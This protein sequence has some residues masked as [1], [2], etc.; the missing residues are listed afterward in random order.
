MSNSAA[1]PLQFIG[2]FD[3]LSRCRLWIALD[4]GPQVSA[5]V[6]PG[7]FSTD[8]RLSEIDLQR[9]KRF[10]SPEKQRQF[11]LSRIAVAEVL[12]Q[13]LG[14]EHDNVRFA[15]DSF[16]RPVV[17]DHNHREV[18]QI[19]LSHSGPVTAIAVSNDVY[20][21][22]VDVELV[23]PI[24]ETALR[25]MIVLP[26]DGKF[27]ASLH[28]VDQSE[29]LRMLWTIKESVWKSLGGKPQIS[30]HEIAIRICSGE[31][32]PIVD[33]DQSLNSSFAVH[34]F[35]MHCVSGTLK[36]QRLEFKERP[37]IAFRGCLTQNMA[38]ATGTLGL[39]AERNRR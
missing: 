10:R 37:E 1:D 21:I 27:L 25:S 14:A 28:D 12:S 2:P 3:M 6:Q 19:S 24:Y 18:R 32:K 36:T 26:A 30:A 20:P 9:W 17:M 31:L 13:E 22:G 23:Q 35:G 4:R 29:C 33:N 15:N 8:S 7:S 39:P 34:L 38:P 16:G 11:L 5:S